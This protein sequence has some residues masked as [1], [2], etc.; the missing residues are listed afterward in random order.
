MKAGQRDQLILIQ[1]KTTT[2][3]DY[4]GE[5][6]AWTDHAQEFAEYKPGTGAE[7][8]QAAQESASLVATFRV[9]DNPKTR[10]VTPGAHR[11]SYD[12][13]FWDITSAVRLGRDGREITATRNADGSQP[14]SA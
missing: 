3:D 11:I 6:E 12:G 4:G 1:R 8:R 5:V 7:R 13:A 14:V 9:L 2:E 10:A